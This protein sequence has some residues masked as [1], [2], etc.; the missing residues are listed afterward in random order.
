MNRDYLEVDVA[1]LHSLTW[2]D[3]DDCSRSVHKDN[4]NTHIE[5][6]VKCSEIQEESSTRSRRSNMIRDFLEV[7]V[8]S[9]HS[10]T[11]SESDDCSRSIH[12][13]IINTHSDIECKCSEIQEESSTRSRH[14]RMNRDYLE[15]DVASLHSRTQ[16]DPDDCSR[17]VHKDNINTH[18]VTEGRCSEAQEESCTRSRRSKTSRD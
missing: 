4:I 3:P 18:S 12:K 15:V 6:E 2:S 17:Y 14:N 1:S 9:P 7:D 13:D 10:L 5:I 11:W 8:A 16:S